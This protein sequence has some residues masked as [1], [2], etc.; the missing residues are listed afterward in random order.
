MLVP[1]EYKITTVQRFKQNAL[2]V[3]ADG[4]HID[5]DPRCDIRRPR[6]ARRES[7]QAES[8]AVRESV[9]ATCRPVRESGETRTRPTSCRLIG[10][11]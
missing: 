2:L 10:T 5:P 1:V 8:R 4:W 6:V 11:L 7:V 3:P 9:R